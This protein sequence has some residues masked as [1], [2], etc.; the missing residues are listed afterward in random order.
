MRVK[1]NSVL[2]QRE[3]AKREIERLVHFTPVSNIYSIFEQ[4]HI[5][6]RDSLNRLEHDE[7]E[8]DIWDYVVTN[9]KLRLDALPEYVNTSVQ[10]INTPLL[11]T[12]QERMGDMC[13]SMCVF[14]L[15][16]DLI[17]CEDTLFSV[18]NAASN[19]S[20]RL[21]I[22]GSFQKFEDIFK[23]DNRSGKNDNEA[24]DIQAEILVKN[25]ISVEYVKQ[26][27]FEDIVEMHT[28]RG[29]ARMIYSRKLP[30]FVVDESFFNL[31]Y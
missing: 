25:K 3:I 20:K 15:S 1:K 11:R 9:D 19:Q 26:V 10:H 24:T 21:G 27:I 8:L 7:N 22:N 13:K 18:G 2:F 16:T 23:G 14:V 28:A 29:A 17:W 31:R 5:L 6:S 30:E 4:G 12:F